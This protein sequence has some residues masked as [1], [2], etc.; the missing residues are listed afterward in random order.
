MYNGQ[1]LQTVKSGE[2]QG[3]T[4]KKQLPDVPC[5]LLNIKARSDNNTN[6]YIGGEDVTVPNG[7]TD[8]TTGFELDAGQETGWMPVDNLNRFWMV[9]D[10]NGDDITY[11]ILY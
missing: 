5:I 3:G 8:V 10:V 9:T 6:V 2:H 4:T 7:Q 1:S 11:S